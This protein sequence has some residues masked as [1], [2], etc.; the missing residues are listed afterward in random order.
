MQGCT[1]GFYRQSIIIKY[2]ENNL[3]TADS[4][5]KMNVGDKLAFPVA[6]AEYIRTITGSRL[7]PERIS[8]MR[9]STVVDKEEGTITVTRIA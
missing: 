8:G 3:T 7:I 9:W 5:R 4:I 2:M 1:A 6:R